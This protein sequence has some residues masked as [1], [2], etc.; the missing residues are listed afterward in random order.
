VFCRYK[1]TRVTTELVVAVFRKLPAAPSR[2]L[3]LPSSGRGSSGAAARR[4][5][6]AKVAASTAQA[7]RLRPPTRRPPGWVMTVEPMTNVMTDAV[8]AAEPARFSDT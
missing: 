5:M 3:R 4:S 8:K 2:S 1:V 7:A 6:T